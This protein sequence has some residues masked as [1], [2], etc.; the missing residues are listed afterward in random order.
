[1]SG[2]SLPIMSVAGKGN[3]GIASSMPLVSLA[4][5]L[6]T[7]NEPMQR[8]L[9]LSFLVATAVIHRIGKAPTM[10]SCEV[11]ASMGVATGAVLLQG[12]T[13]EQV[14]IAIQNLI[15]NVFGVVCDGAK[16]ACALRMASGTAIALDAAEMALKGVRL[17]NNQGVLDKTADD[18]IDFLGD[19]ALNDMI[20]SDKKLEAKMMEK[21][22]IFP[23]TTFTDR[24]KQ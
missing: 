12:G 18:S 2:V 14:E 1:M 10:C 3:V 17:A 7:G 8:A 4:K 22:R 20:T 16:L 23:L 15:P 6:G 24:Q 13:E 21:R 11:A 5:D 19:F 9:A